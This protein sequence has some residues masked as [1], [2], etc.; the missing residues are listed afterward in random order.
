VG[1]FVEIA[2]AVTNGMENVVTSLSSYSF[3]FVKDVITCFIINW[4]SYG[5]LYTIFNYPND[6][7]KNSSIV[8]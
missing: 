4:F 2:W 7:E 3:P 6:L 8:R 5:I 1:D